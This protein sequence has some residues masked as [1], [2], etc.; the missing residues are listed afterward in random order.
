MNSVEMS[1]K[2]ENLSKKIEV[3]KERQ[4]KIKQLKITTK[5]LWV[6]SIVEWK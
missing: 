3:K 5:L 2:I 6:G 1:E 4:M